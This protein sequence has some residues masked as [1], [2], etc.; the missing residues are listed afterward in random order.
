MSNE[1]NSPPVFTSI[2]FASTEFGYLKPAEHVFRSTGQSKGAQEEV[3]VVEEHDVTDPNRVY[4]ASDRQEQPQEHDSANDDLEVGDGDSVSVS[5]N[6][7]ALEAAE[8]DAE[9]AAIGGESEQTQFS[10]LAQDEPSVIDEVRE[11]VLAEV[12]QALGQSV[13]VK[14]V[15]DMSERDKARAEVEAALS[16]GNDQELER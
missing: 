3:I 8:I 11:A 5:S 16:R 1:T 6:E 2:D 13:Q 10:N 12:E 7:S 9:I 15:A 4:T 14:K